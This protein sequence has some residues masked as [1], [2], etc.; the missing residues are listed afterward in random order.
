MELRATG[1]WYVTLGVCGRHGTITQS[2]LGPAQGS[3]VTVACPSRSF[4][5]SATG[6]GTTS[7]SKVLK[8]LQCEGHTPLG[9]PAA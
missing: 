6:K 7:G 2:P 1:T 9:G 8:N 4:P 3:A 5:T